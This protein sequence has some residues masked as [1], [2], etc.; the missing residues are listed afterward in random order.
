MEP[1]ISHLSFYYRSSKNLDLQKL[2][3]VWTDR[4]W[5]SWGSESANNV[6]ILVNQEFFKVPFNHFQAQDP[7]SF[8][9]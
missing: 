6:S 5:S 8:P 3:N 2:L 7:W 9:L 1:H 4:G